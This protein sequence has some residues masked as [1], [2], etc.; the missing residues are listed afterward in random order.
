MRQVRSIV[1][2]AAREVVEKGP[3]AVIPGEAGN[4]SDSDAK[5][6]RFFGT[7]RA[8]SNSV[9]AFCPALRAALYAAWA[10]ARSGRPACGWI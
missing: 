5:R 8:S 10:R 4:L 2:P 9:E 3:R 6:K 7:Q 1:M